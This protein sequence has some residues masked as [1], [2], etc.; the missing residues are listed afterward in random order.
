[1]LHCY[2][3]LY[4]FDEI[5]IYI[6]CSKPP[7]NYI[8]PSLLNSYSWIIFDCASTCSNQVQLDDIVQK[9]LFI[10]SQ[11]FSYGIYE[12]KLTVTT[13]DRSL[14]VVSSIY[15]KIID[16]NLITNLISFNKFMIKHYS[17]EILILD[18]GKYSIDENKIIFNFHVSH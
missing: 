16:S 2:Q 5:K 3:N 14:T 17:K 7:L 6:S 9:E 15:I 12:F 8:P 11:T 10:P 18:P 1:M 13:I 4:S